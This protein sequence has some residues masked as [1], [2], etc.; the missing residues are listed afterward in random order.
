[1]NAWLRRYLAVG[2]ELEWMDWKGPLW[3]TS[4]SEQLSIMAN[5]GSM[6]TE[7]RFISLRE[8]R[9]LAQA[10]GDEVGRLDEAV[11]WLTSPG[12]DENH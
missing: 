6:G 12:P 10:V 4:T 11:A 2:I 1:M 3:I 7:H 9:E 5:N 8:V